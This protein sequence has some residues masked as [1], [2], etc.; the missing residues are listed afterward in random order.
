MHHFV[1]EMYV[2]VHISVTKWCIF[3]RPSPCLKIK[4]RP[5]QK[6]DIVH[7]HSLHDTILY[8]LTR[9]TDMEAHSYEI[10]YNIYH[11]K[12]HIKWR[13]LYEISYEIKTSYL[14]SN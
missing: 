5:P 2:Y 12:F 11:V 4:S 8:D 10:F 9:T 7:P 3:D 14:I 6:V 1:T 13:F